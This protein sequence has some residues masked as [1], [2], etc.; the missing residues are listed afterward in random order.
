M[1]LT[2][3]QSLIGAYGLALLLWWLAHRLLPHLWTTTYEPQ[4]KTPW[5]ELL[6]V[7]LATIVILSIGVV[8]S[9]YG[10]IPKPKYGA[11]LI[12]ILNQV[13]IF[14][15]AILWFLWRKDAWASAWLPNQL[16]VQRIF[17]GLAIALGAIGFFLVLR[18]G[19]KGYVQVFMEVY[20]PKNLGYLAQVLG[21]DFIIALFFVRFQALLGKR[22]A[23]VIVAALFAAGHIPAFL[24][25][26]VTWVEMQSLIFDALL[27]VGILSA[28]QRSSD[29][30]WFWMVHFAMDMMQFYSTSPK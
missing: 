22:L 14:S 11:F 28:L 2:H 15:P 9:R 4:F 5:K 27:S 19:S 17:I 13:I 30:W 8:Y 29:I 10:L 12:S 23:I 3:Y 16:I 21:E 7:I 26:G 24:A 20:H 6:G 1:E 18:E 25:N